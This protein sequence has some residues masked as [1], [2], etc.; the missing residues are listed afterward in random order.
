MKCSLFPI[1]L[2]LLCMEFLMRLGIGIQG[3]I[4][5]VSLLYW[6]RV[7]DCFT[8]L[9]FLKDFMICTEYEQHLSF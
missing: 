6:S 5:F 2:F 1:L 4:L 8:S 9:V 7:L 3:S